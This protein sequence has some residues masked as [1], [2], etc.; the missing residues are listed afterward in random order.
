MQKS[1]DELLEISSRKSKQ[2]HSDVIFTVN[3][4]HKLKLWYNRGEIHYVN[5]IAHLTKGGL[6]KPCSAGS[7]RGCTS[8]AKVTEVV[9]LMCR[10]TGSLKHIDFE[11]EILYFIMPLSSKW[12]EDLICA[13]Q[14]R[15]GSLSW[16]PEEKRWTIEAENYS[17][18]YFS[19]TSQTLKNVHTLFSEK[20]LKGDLNK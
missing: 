10:Y 13:L 16:D 11:D 4:Q 12:S 5:F 20:W 3:R 1:L 7:C 14:R 9:S 17:K 6:L 19:G 18:K 15:P 8:K 2:K